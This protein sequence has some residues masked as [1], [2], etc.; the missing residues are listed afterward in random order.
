MPT[1]YSTSTKAKS[2]EVMRRMREITEDPDTL[3]LERDQMIRE[4]EARLFEPSGLVIFR[5][6]RY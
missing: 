1:R 2:S 4:Q 6:D 5:F 3:E